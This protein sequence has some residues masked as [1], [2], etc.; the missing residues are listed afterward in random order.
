MDCSP[1]GSSVYGILPARIPEWV[2]IS[3]SRGSSQPRD[4]TRVFSCNAGRLYHLSHQ[5]RPGSTTDIRAFLS[6]AATCITPQLLPRTHLLPPNLCLCNLPRIDDH[7]LIK[8]HSLL[9]SCQDFY[10]DPFIKFGTC[11]FLRFSLLWSLYMLNIKLRFRWGNK[12]REVE[13][14][15]AEVT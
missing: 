4:W 10:A 14:I 7:F 12:D 15:K 11:R 5:G 9:F 8:T 1:P 13:E 6:K 3:F 2:A